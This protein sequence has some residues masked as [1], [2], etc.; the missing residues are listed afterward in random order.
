M[1]TVYSHY[2]YLQWHSNRLMIMIRVYSVSWNVIIRSYSLSQMTKICH[3]VT[4]QIK[5][6]KFKSNQNQ[7]K[8]FQIIFVL[9]SNH[10]MWFNHDLN[11]I[12]IGFCPSLESRFDRTQIFTDLVSFWISKWRLG[13]DYG[14]RGWYVY[15][16]V[17]KVNSKVR[18]WP[19]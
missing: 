7:I 5:S 18:Q 6:Q 3:L 14:H 16:N 11:Q 10:H 1:K 17:R 15:R 13:S 2:K 4:S 8:G 12:M 19:T 9:K